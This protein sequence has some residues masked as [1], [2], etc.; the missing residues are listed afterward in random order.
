M[1]DCEKHVPDATEGAEMHDM[2]QGKNQRKMLNFRAEADLTETK[3]IQALNM[4]GKGLKV[5]H[6]PLHLHDN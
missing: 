3:T 2:L 1:A 5:F 4:F 6:F